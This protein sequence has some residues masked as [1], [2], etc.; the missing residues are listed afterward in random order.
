MFVHDKM[1]YEC[2][3]CGYSTTR[4]LNFTRHKNRKNSCMKTDDGNVSTQN[5]NEKYKCVDRENINA[6]QENINAER[7]NINVNNLTCKQ[8]KKQLCD[9][10]SYEYHIKI[11]KG[12]NSKT[13]PNCFKVF[14]SIQGKYQHI[15]NVKCSPPISQS[16]HPQ[17][18][19]TINN[20]NIDNR[21][22][23]NNNTVNNTNCNNQNVQINVFGS[24][25]LSYLLKDKGIVHRLRMY[26]KEGLYGL[27][28]IL[29]DVH[30][31][32]DRPENHTII[33]P[34]EYGNIVLIKN[35]NNEWEFREFEDI[36]ENM[37]DT[38]IKYF[39]AYNEVK[40]SMNIDLVEEKEK[41]FIKKISY[42][43]M[44]L[45]GYIPR[46]LFYELEMD[47]NKVEENE[48]VLKN[49]TRKFDKSTMHMI[50]N[51]TY[52][53]YKKENGQYVKK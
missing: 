53:T 42:E 15:K 33:K 20:N 7:E 28:K 51:R 41:N 19:S 36:R 47:E 9:K 48:D 8:C 34:E 1:K 3:D 5:E 26:G 43:L 17:V 44:A 18:N 49:K 46:D 29:D 52:Y 22:T 23:N 14:S 27:P 6:N 24:E 50:H 32:K 39:R 45:E 40:K 2:D 10:K 30:F 12:V 35:S 31:N 16:L 25:D 38:I 13:C 37:I 11:C 21:V 4:K